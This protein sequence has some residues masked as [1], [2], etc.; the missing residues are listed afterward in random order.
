MY[1]ECDSIETTMLGKPKLSEEALEDETP[2]GEKEKPRSIE[3][4]II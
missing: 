4:P 2:G 3:T 1:Q